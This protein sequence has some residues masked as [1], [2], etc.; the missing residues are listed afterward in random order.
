[1]GLPKDAFDLIDGDDSRRAAIKNLSTADFEACPGS[2]KTTLLVAKLAI[3]ANLW[4][5]RR[6]GICVLSHTN[7]A[8]D[9]I[10]S[11]LNSCAAGV[12]LLRYPHFVG[13]IHS[14]VNEFLAI[15]WLRSKGN[16]IKAIDS[17][18]ALE[19]RWRALLW[20]TKHYLQ[21][22]F[23]DK[24]A[25]AYDRVDFGGG[26]KGNLGEHTPTYKAMVAQSRANSEAGYFCYDEMFVWG[27]ELVDKCPDVITMI[28]GRFPYVFIDEAQDNSELQSA[29]LSRLFCEGATPSKR[30]RFG[31]SNQAIYQHAAAT[32]ATTDV[33]PG[34]PKYDIPRSYR[35]G[36]GIADQ[37]KPFGVIPQQLVGAGPSRALIVDAPRPST[38]FLFDDQSVGAVLSKYGDLLIAS[39]TEAELAKGTFT[40]VAA[41]HDTDEATPI[42][43]SIQHY[44]PS[45]NAACARKEAAPNSFAQFL[46][47][48]RF[49][50]NGRADAH[51]LVSG[52]AEAVLH[53]ASLYGGDIPISG[54]RTPHRRIRELLADKAELA[55]YDELIAL[56]IDQQGDLSPVE[57]DG[58]A[59]SLASDAA[60]A[61]TGGR[62]ST[63]D[64][65]T[66][67]RWPMTEDT[68]GLDDGP[69]PRS[70]NLFG[71]PP[72][73]PK[74]HIRLGS[75]HSV[76]GE[77]HTSTLVLESY[78]HDYHFVQL[79]PW[80]LGAKLGGF[81][82]TKSES[83]RMLGRLRL[84]YVAMTRPSHLLC[85]AM[86][87]DTLN[88]EER[89]TLGQRG[90]TVVDCL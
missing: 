10:G 46:G 39:F 35:F 8:R 65:F 68:A 75:I 83:S 2:G 30:Q 14:F 13:T 31:D 80:L 78:F 72:T 41:V 29:F 67:M 44:A 3:M 25:L 71:Y 28:R 82:G 45:Y 73:D 16:P 62:Q 37:V 53:L 21:K 77:T 36:Q 51:P 20:N 87:R 26:S 34:T 54:R 4:G 27:R 22:H 74:V 12:A 42:P 43:R 88:A 55:S 86:R 15:P 89:T 6:Q 50:M 19:K 5:S 66:F 18:I 85:V 11:R 79:K 60:A 84:H 17:E 59:S 7:A 47:R 49:K 33:F 64:V 52:V 24:Y 32:G 58:K 57:W 90:W 81:T 38:I 48:A 63:P 70:D 9:E 1:M 23:L 61:I 69:P 76:K 56:V 40:A